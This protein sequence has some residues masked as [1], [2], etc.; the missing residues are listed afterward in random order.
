MM[1]KRISC[2]W[3]FMVLWVLCV[4]SSTGYAIDVAPNGRS[5]RYFS[6]GRQVREIAWRKNNMLRR[7]KVYDKNGRLAQDIVYRDGK[8]VVKKEYYSNGRLKS[9]SN[10]LTNK[11]MF[12]H[13][14]GFLRRVIS[15]EMSPQGRAS[16]KQKRSKR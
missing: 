6:G 14:D 1:K 3:F 2:L 13:Q 9:V 11:V 12:Y 15:S 8:I 4:F 7:R 10:A 16:S 5:I